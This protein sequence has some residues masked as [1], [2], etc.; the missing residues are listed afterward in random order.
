[1]L[2]SEESWSAEG[3]TLYLM[4]A[5]NLLSGV[6]YADTPYISNP[7]KTLISP[8]SYPPGYPLILVPVL[9]LVGMNIFV[10]KAVNALLLALTLVTLYLIA[11]TRMPP[12]WPIVLVM[13][14]GASPAFVGSRD[15]IMSEAPFMVWCY[16]ALLVA[17]ALRR[18]YRPTTM[19]TLLVVTIVMAIRTRT[20][21]I[22]LAAAVLIA[23]IIVR[24]ERKLL[25]M[26]AA[27]AA[28]VIAAAVS[29]WLHV[30]GTTYL[31][32]FSRMDLAEAQSWLLGALSAYGTAVSYG[33]GL[34]F[35]YTVNALVL[36]VL[37]AAIVFGFLVAIR[38]QVTEVDVFVI[39]YLA[40]LVF[41]PVHLESLRYLLPIFP[42]LLL[43]M[44]KGC[45]IVVSRFAAPVAS[46]G[47]VLVFFGC[48]YTPFYLV[49]DQ[50]EQPRTHT[51]DAS[52]RQMFDFVR[53]HMDSDEI[54][55]T[56]KPRLM[57]FATGYRASIWPKHPT[58]Q[59]FW[60]SAQDVKAGY[61]LEERQD[62]SPKTAELGAIL[63][64]NS[65]RLKCIFENDKIRIYQ[66]TR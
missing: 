42:F 26:A 13:I 29:R 41:F 66:I 3:Y 43:Y 35:G 32:Y 53:T 55:L 19:A 56:R 65:P 28:V 1:M 44:I 9:T 49:H 24:S 37:L 15:G 40:L 2:R 25:P 20:A 57:A 45:Q 30:D 5:R 47:I 31:S 8:R 64:E 50:M 46:Q 12:G 4:H 27:T 14:C 17:G 39:G 62:A 59:S 54:L 34:E 61:L 10:I 22:A 63:T 33:I 52:S 6:P 36:V 38:A 48:L 7:L 18:G 11:H 21:G 58:S 16:T 23:P 51:A 60:A